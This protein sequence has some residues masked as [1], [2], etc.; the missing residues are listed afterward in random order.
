[1]PVETRSMR[2]ARMLR[3]RTHGPRLA[4]AIAQAYL[5]RH[6]ASPA[7]SPVGVPL[8]PPAGLLS[9]ATPLTALANTAGIPLSTSFSPSMF[10]YV[11]SPD[12]SPLRLPAR[13]QQSRR[14]IKRYRPR[15]TAH[16]HRIDD[17]QPKTQRVIS[18]VRRA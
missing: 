9:P 6:V 16:R 4:Q 10:D 14:W 13:T 8:S 11:P 5:N 2:Q 15:D 18:Y 12:M 1:M 17:D 3:A 7:F